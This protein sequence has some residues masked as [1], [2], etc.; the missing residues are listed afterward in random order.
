M[1]NRLDV[2]IFGKRAM[3][4]DPIM[5]IGGEKSTYPIPTY[6]ALKGIMDSIYWKPTFIWVIDRLRIMNPIKT[7]SVNVK[8]RKYSEGNDLSIYTYLS[9]VN[10]EIQAH[11]EWNLNR[12]D[13]INDRDENKHYFSAKRMLARGGRYDIFLG[14][15]E[16][17]GY[18]EPCVFG[19]NEGAYDNTPSTQLSLMFHGFDYP[20]NTGKEGLIARFW[21]PVMSNGII[22][23]IRPEDCTI[24]KQ[25]KQMP[26]P[27]GV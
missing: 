25:V 6:E 5:R 7:E 20:S 19:E 11:F 12:E 8:T 27:E 21:H 10:Y 18:V 17:Q 16:C 13:L 24:R 23:F 14:T 3:F 15:R 22:E 1:E 4:S 2:K 26:V 9:N